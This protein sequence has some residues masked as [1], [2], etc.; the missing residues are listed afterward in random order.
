M[1]VLEFH[2][3]GFGQFANRTVGHLDHSVTIFYGPNEAGKST[4]LEFI[5]CT[6]FGFPLRG[7]ARHYP[8]LAGGQH[9]GSMTITASGLDDDQAIDRYTVRRFQG[10]GGGPV[11]I[12][13]G[14]GEML[15]EA[16]L[17][18]LL[19][20]HSKEVFQ[21]VFAFTLDE[22]HSDDLLKDDRVNSQIYSAGMGAMSLPSAVK[23]IQS[24]REALFR[25]GGSSQEIHNTYADLQTIDSKI[26][27]V[28]GN[29]ARYAILTAKLEQVEED[30]DGLNELR[31][32]RQSELDRWRR[33]EN[34]WDDWHSL[35]IADQE[36]HRLPVIEH[37]PV[38]GVSR[39]EAFDERVGSARQEH[40]AA[41]R[42]LAEANVK[43]ETP[44]EH[45][46]ILSHSQRIRSLERGRT[47]FDN[48]VHD[49]P[50][51]KAELEEHRTSFL[52]TMREIGPDW[53]EARLDGFDLPITANQEIS[54]FGE[55]LRDASE[56]SRAAESNLH[57]AEA[58]FEETAGHV[59]QEAILLYSDDIRKLERGR[60]SFDN[61]VHD[62]PE[63]EAELDEHRTSLMQTLRDIG[64]D[65]DEARLDGFDLSIAIREEIAQ[66][67]ERLRDANGELDRRESTLAQDQTQLDEARQQE[68]AAQRNLDSRPKPTT[69]DEQIRERR[70]LIRTMESRLRQ[71]QLDRER[72]SVLQDQLDAIAGPAAPAQ[73]NTIGKAIA[74]VA[75]LFGIAL[76]VVAADAV[77]GGSSLPVSA[78]VVIALI[79]GAPFVFL[80]IR[81]SY[82]SDDDSA[83]ADPI[84][85][86]IDRA[87]SEMAELQATLQQDAASLGL[88]TVDET[89]IIAAQGSLDEDETALRTWTTLSEILDRARELTRRRTS[90]KD[91]SREAVTAAKA[92][93]EAARKEW[94]D[95]L[96]AR[97]LRD[98]F[99]PNT[100]VELR[101]KVDLGLTQLRDLRSWRQRV[102]AIQE[103]IDEYVDAISPLAAAF[104]VAFDRNDPRS[105]A[106]AADRLIELHGEVE[107]RVRDRTSAE[108]ERDNA[109]LQ[110]A[111]AK[112]Q[113]DVVQNEWKE[114]L[115]GYGLR[116]TFTPDTVAKLQEQ[117]KTG[118]SHLANVRS[119]RQRVG[120]IQEDIDEYID[121]VSPLAAVFGVALDRNDPRT[122]ADAADRLIDLHNEVEGKDR[123]RTDADIDREN[124]VRQLEARKS[125]LRKAN[126]EREQLLSS[127]GAV[128]GEDFRR[129]A[130]FHQQRND[131]EAKRID[132]R[133]RLQR[134]SGPGEPLNSLTAE[135]RST[136]RQTVDAEIRRLEEERAEADS[137][138]EK[139]STERGSIQTE[140]NGLM[141]EEESSALRLQRNVLLEQI[142]VHAHEW[143]K[144][145]IARNL[146]EEAR[147]KFEQER[148][149]G[150]VRHAQTFFTD[151][152][153]GRYRQVYAPL[154]QQTITVNDSDGLRKEPSQ[155]SRGAREQLFLSLRFGLIRELGQRTE[156]LPVV[157][158]EVL[159]NFDR[160]RAFR[161]ALAFMELS[162]TNQVLVFTCHPSV[163][164]LFQRA[165]S[166]A[167]EKAPHVKE[168]T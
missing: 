29:A 136:D 78:I 159:V 40:D 49:L 68:E 140:R 109:R 26:Q 143:T 66:Y 131:L 23:A 10:R 121:A 4:Y 156:P 120:A 18:K 79:T 77:L 57:Q 138:I 75:G 110:F 59:E 104:G 48:S 53:N 58:A 93:I 141:N 20:H 149:P 27:E 11:T 67:E 145:T 139:L 39:L 160:D 6:L 14:A 7:G 41:H 92:Q 157:V 89:S 69:D 54:Q 150:V 147:R 167:G 162:R 5:R 146:L 82:R 98:T 30:L 85:E 60:T 116:D 94:R 166:E 97:G 161:A 133:G 125:A 105:A 90:R 52:Q 130:E 134:I 148:Q 101:G 95:W 25:K 154:G 117:V 135:L 42:L 122:V 106:D 107:R 47:S 35:V 111:E 21:N 45:E 50:E 17:S 115:Q 71:L 34:A 127:G 19:G 16:A 70:A 43:A 22:L 151:I 158:D 62:L 88:E 155:L 51:R 87:K 56:R 152:T 165:A 86:S 65:W 96:R 33:I 31:R 8:P 142:Q 129:R 114:R 103:D 74:A 119:W 73:P 37:F 44:I 9:G 28:A 55:R 72:I 113:L 12:T 15:D 36:L 128:D 61:S 118:R 108:A 164:G 102:D 38:D 81:S 13:N 1:R 80:Y 3:D 83:R 126:H 46:A 137:A 132:A 91:L 123:D 168:I 144:L 32:K 124:A 2:I 63:R 99:A 100:V 153:Q 24:R 112:Q 64:P 84:R 76:G 163:V